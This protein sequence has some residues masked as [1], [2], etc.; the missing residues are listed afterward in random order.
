MPH[1]FPNENEEKPTE[2]TCG[3]HMTAE[4]RIYENSYDNIKP[5]H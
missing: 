5:L 3:I 4:G 2:K 1:Q